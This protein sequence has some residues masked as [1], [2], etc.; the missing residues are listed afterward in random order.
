[1]RESRMGGG[2]EESGEG[3]KG[4]RTTMP[5][6]TCLEG[7]KREGKKARNLYK[8]LEG[9]R[10]EVV[11]LE[12]E[13]LKAAEEK[14]KR[15]KKEKGGEEGENGKGDGGQR[16]EGHVEVEEEDVEMEEA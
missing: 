3:K 15:K 9:R 16:Q 11:R 5:R 2:S 14:R 1:M 7:I 13:R 8:E 10:E 4:D 6:M 12:R